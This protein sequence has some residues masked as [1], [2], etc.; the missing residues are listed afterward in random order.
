LEAAAAMNA[1]GHEIGILYKFPIESYE[2]QQPEQKEPRH[3]LE[4]GQP[5]VVYLKEQRMFLLSWIAREV[6]LCGLTSDGEFVGSKEGK[7]L[8]FVH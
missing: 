1:S 3:T 2:G 8:G 5:R 4:L 6:A 7:A